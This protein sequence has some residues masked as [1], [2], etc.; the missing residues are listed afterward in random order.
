MIDGS[1]HT[2]RWGGQRRHPSDGG[3]KRRVL[4]VS[5]SLAVSPCRACRLGQANPE[6]IG[7]QESSAEAMDSAKAETSTNTGFSASLRPRRHSDGLGVVRSCSLL[8]TA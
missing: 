2:G 4:S 5:E 8:R 6:E 1:D 3:S 7:P